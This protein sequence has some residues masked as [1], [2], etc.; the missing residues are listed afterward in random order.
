MAVSH[1]WRIGQAEL[2][3]RFRLDLD[4]FARRR[5]RP[6][7]AARCALTSLPKPGIVNSP[8]LRVWV[9]AVSISRLKNAA[10]CLGATSSCS[11]MDRI[12]C[13]VVILIAG[14]F[15]PA[16]SLVGVHFL[17]TVFRCYLLGCQ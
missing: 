11:A 12:T 15:E 14:S 4:R 1:P 2:H 8:F 5:V 13:V 17:A 6:I 10:I 3:G 16:G 9:V 7:R